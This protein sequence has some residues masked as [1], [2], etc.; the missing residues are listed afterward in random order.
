MAALR[1]SA[2]VFSDVADFLVV[3]IE[4]AHPVDGWVFVGNPIRV[5]VHRRLADRVD[6][7]GRLVRRHA[8]GADVGGVWT[9]VVDDMDNNAN[10]AY[11]GLFA[12]LYVVLRGIAVYQ[13]ERG[14]PGCRVTD[15]DDWLRS[16]RD[17]LLRTSATAMATPTDGLL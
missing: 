16:Y 15:V 2:A 12:R 14:P 10:R 7:A 17:Q 1:R 9:V 13:G 8:D 3:Y 4:E 6:A 11:G 5:A